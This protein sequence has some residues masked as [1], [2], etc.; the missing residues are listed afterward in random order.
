MTTNGPL[1]PSQ[2]EDAL[3]KENAKDIAEAVET[4]LVKLEEKKPDSLEL[5]FEKQKILSDRYKSKP[6][7]YFVNERFKG[8]RMIDLLV[9]ID[10][11]GS[12]LRRALNWKWWKNYEN[13]YTTNED[14]SYQTEFL[15]DEDKA[16]QQ[17]IIENTTQEYIQK[18]VVDMWHFL[19][20]LTIE[21]GL[22]AKKLVEMYLDKN[23]TNHD[24][25][26]HGY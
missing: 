2:I 15:T 22:D 14:D 8:S 1:T 10:D 9:A 20:Q 23:K 16:T 21:A 3:L 18:E 12:E 17:Q 13:D 5:I 4:Y 11:E 26:D 25:Q 24:R 7:N 6:D 19:V